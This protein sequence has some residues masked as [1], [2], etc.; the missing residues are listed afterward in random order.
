MTDL[1][2]QLSEATDGRTVDRIVEQNINK[3]RDP[4]DRM[5]FCRWANNAKRR[6]NRVKRETNKS[7][8]LYEKN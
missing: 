8:R 4:F 6:I 7:F 2:I 3:L 5:F 1:I